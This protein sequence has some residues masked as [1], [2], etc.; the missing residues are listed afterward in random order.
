MVIYAVEKGDKVGKL[1]KVLGSKSF[2]ALSNAVKMSANMVQKEW[3]ENVQ[4]SSTKQGWKK[5]YIRSINIDFENPLSATVSVDEENKFVNFVEDGIKR[6]DMK[7]ITDSKTPILT[8]KGYVKIKDIKIGNLVLT[9]KGKFKRVLEVF[10]EKCEDEYIYRIKTK[11][12]K[13]SVTG[14]HP[15]LTNNGW[16]RADE[17][18]NS[19]DKIKVLAE[20]C[21]YCGKLLEYDYQAKR[22]SDKSIQYCNK[23]CAAKNNNKFRKKYGRIDLNAE[24]RNNIRK[25]TIETN[26]RLAKE[27]K[28]ASQPGG[29]LY[30]QTKNNKNWGIG[31]FTDKKKKEY[32]HKA[33]VALGKK[34][35]NTD[36]ESKMESILINLGFNVIF[37][38]DWNGENCKNLWIRQFLVKRKNHFRMHR[39]KK[40]HNWFFL[41]FYNPYYNICIETNGEQWHTQKQDEE[42]K[43][44]LEIDYKMRYLSF[45]SKEVYREKDKVINEVKRILNN[46]KGNYKFIESEFDIEKYKRK[47][48]FSHL[49]KYNMTIEEDSSYIAGHSIV[50]HNSGLLKSSKAKTNKDGDKYITIFMR[51]G[52]PGAKSIPN[53]PKT[54]YKKIR[55]AELAQKFARSGSKYKAVLK[56]LRGETG[57]KKTGKASIYEGLTKMGGKG[58]SQYGTFRIVTKNSTGWIH[59][60]VPASK[61]FSLTSRRVK[62]RIKRMLQEGL[63]LD[64]QA[65]MEYLSK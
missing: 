58:Q 17:L 31:S 2:P 16:K 35:F 51:K 61:V 45:W 65:G 44:E 59:P 7:C 52:T 24:A 25:K 5:E 41:D 13:V 1:L 63:S 49:R 11:K 42:R 34:H 60:G 6:F 21:N 62:P 39:G 47:S 46:H 14:N 43:K 18:N 8:S 20:K 19:V 64:I 10:N 9:H 32:A 22:D 54:I 4:K 36:L 15:I 50:T 3:A 26:K 37:S 55:K 56:G 28:H 38:K 30:K 23:S 33:A 27:G 57:S 29:N 53:M 12:G 40:I 48:K